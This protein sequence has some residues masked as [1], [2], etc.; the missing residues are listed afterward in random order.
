MNIFEDL[1]KRNF[2][3]NENICFTSMFGLEMPKRKSCNIEKDN[4]RTFPERKKMAKYQ[5]MSESECLRNLLDF[6]DRKSNCCKFLNSNE[7][8][9]ATH[10]M[11]R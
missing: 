7:I 2:S 8:I 9:P 6:C 5:T 3:T 10:N 4:I 11:V 1:V